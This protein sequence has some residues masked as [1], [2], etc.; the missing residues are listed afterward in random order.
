MEV[1]GLSI[2]FLGIIRMER[3]GVEKTQGCGVNERS[4]GMRMRN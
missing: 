1:H 2:H 4:Q 3:E